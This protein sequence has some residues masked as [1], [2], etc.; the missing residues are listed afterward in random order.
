MKKFFVFVISIFLFSQLELLCVSKIIVEKGNAGQNGKY[1][2]VNEWHFH[3]PKCDCDV[4][5]LSCWEPGYINCEWE[6][7]PSMMRL[8]EY[9][10]DQIRKGLLNGT[11]EEIIDGIRHTVEWNATNIYNA[12]ITETVYDT[13]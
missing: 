8:V 12:N 1:N 6:H 13:N 2:K 9:A 7:R 5:K 10:E 4:H 3:D 11:Y